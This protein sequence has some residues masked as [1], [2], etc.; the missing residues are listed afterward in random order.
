MLAGRGI[1][2]YTTYAHECGN[3]FNKEVPRKACLFDFNNRK[4]KLLVLP[5]FWK[6]LSL[7]SL[8]EHKCSAI[9]YHDGLGHKTALADSH[10]LD[11]FQA[12]FCGAP[13]RL[14]ELPLLI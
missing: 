3:L 7:H 4:R 10:R 1:V 6:R 13:N 14:M 11:A 8:Q 9:K 5:Q 2:V 12:C